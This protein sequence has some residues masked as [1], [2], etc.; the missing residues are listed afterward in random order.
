MWNNKNS[1][2]VMMGPR[3]NFDKA[4]SFLHRPPGPNH[5]VKNWRLGRRRIPMLKKGGQLKR[6]TCLAD[7]VVDIYCNSDRYLFIVYTVVSCIFSS[8]LEISK[9]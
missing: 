8:L 4:F 2:S 6:E 1:R 7:V 5:P 9:M 3:C